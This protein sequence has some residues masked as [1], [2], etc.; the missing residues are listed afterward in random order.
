VRD[1]SGPEE[2][3]NVHWVDGQR[4]RNAGGIDRSF[5]ARGEG[6]RADHQLKTLDELVDEASK[7]SFPASDPPSFWARGAGDGNSSEP[8]KAGRMEERSREP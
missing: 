2:R 8:A 4:G 3:E 1:V 7:E 6:A 5:R